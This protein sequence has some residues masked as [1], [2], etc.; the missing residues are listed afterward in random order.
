MRITCCIVW[1]LL[2]VYLTFE[3]LEYN[4]KRNPCCLKYL[5]CRYVRLEVLGRYER[6]R[7]CCRR[8]DGHAASEWY[9]AGLDSMARE[10][11]ALPILEERICELTS[12]KG[13]GL[14][15]QR[16]DGGTRRILPIPR[17]EIVLCITCGN[18]GSVLDT[19]RPRI[20]WQE[21][22]VLQHVRRF[23][24]LGLHKRRG[25]CRRGEDG[26]AA[27]E[28]GPTAFNNWSTNV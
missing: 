10:V 25:A 28:D 21:R 3:I 27:A 6:G 15:P 16:V 18:L 19:W 9:L 7:T 20:P 13:S 26:P 17:R 1:E 4:S 14:L 11:L 23:D 22:L 12:W 2:R 5:K 8:E 24:V